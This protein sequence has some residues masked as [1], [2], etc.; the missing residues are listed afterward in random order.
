MIWD[1]G[2][3]TCGN[4]VPIVDDK[5]RIHLLMTWNYQTDK[6]G[7]ITNGTGENTRRP[8]YTYSDDD[9]VTWA[10]PVEITSAVKKEKWDW[11]AT[12]PCHGIQI[13]KG[14]N[15]GRLNCSKLFYY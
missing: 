12:G 1:D 10:S 13:Q 11:Y 7:T 8:Y 9:G 14:T 3:N 2:Q 5:G 4:P 6:W 15:R